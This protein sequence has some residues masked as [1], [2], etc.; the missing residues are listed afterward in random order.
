MII[1]TILSFL[2]ALVTGSYN[3]INTFVK[4]YGYGAIFILMALESSSLPIPSEI[5]LPLAGLFAATGTLNFTFALV[6]AM[7]GSILGSVV[8]YV[9]GYVIGKDVVYKNLKFFHLK[10]ESLDNFDRWFEKNGNAAVFFTRLVP[11]ARTFINFP[12]GFA[13]MSF[14]KFMLYSIAGMLIWDVVLMGFGFYLLSAHSAVI[15]LAS[16]GV[17]ALLLYVIYKLA[18][19]R[20]KK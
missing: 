4:S 3:V 16:I 20:M 18:L 19:K 10:K 15:V 13:K 7:L 1:L 9:I 6:A 14:K 8:D 12:A 5:V 17:F 11:V 2:K